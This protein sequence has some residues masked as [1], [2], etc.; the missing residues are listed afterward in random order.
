MEGVFFKRTRDRL[1][2]VL[3]MLKP[4]ETEERS[5]CLICTSHRRGKSGLGYPEIKRDGRTVS[6]VRHLW[7]RERGPIAPGL[8]LHNTCGDRSCV[9]LDHY[10]PLTSSALVVATCSR[11]EDKPNNK[12]T[13][14]DVRGIKNSSH[15]YKKLAS[16]YSVSWSTIR[17]IRKGHRWKHVS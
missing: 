17:N 15:G 6:V 16:E 14:D 7:E 12:L 4:I 3:V 5:G 2:S 8:F 11:G 9:S 1:S 10:E 13:E